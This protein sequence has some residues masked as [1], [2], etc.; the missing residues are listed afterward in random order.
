M[1]REQTN[2]SRR[3]RH[4]AEIRDFFGRIILLIQT[5]LSVIA[6]IFVWRANLLPAKFLI[7][8]LAVLAALVVGCYFLM[9]NGIHR[10]RFYIGGV[11]SVA[12]SVVLI[13]VIVVMSQMTGALRGIT[14]A[15]VETSTVCVYVLEEDSAQSITDVAG[16]PF[17]ILSSLD[18]ENTED[19]IEQIEEETAY[20]ISCAEYDDLGD[21]ADALLDGECRSI[22]LNEGFVGVL[23]DLEGYEEFDTQI[24]EIARYETEVIVEKEEEMT[25]E[26]VLDQGSFVLYISGIDTTGDVS[27]KGRSD[28]NILAVVNTDTRQILLVSTPRDYYVEL[29]ISNGVRDKLTHAGIYG[30]QVSMDTLEMLYDVDINY[31]FRLNFTGF[32]EV[33]DALGGIDV[34]SDYTFDG[35]SNTHFVKGMNHL[36]GAEA[37]A[38]ARERYSFSEGDRQRGKNQ[39]EVIRATLDAVMSPA[40]LRNFSGFMSSLEHS[41]DTDLPYDLLSELVKG[42]LQ[43]MS[44]W[45]IVSYS[46]NGSDSRSTT[47]SMNRS[48][49]VMIPDEETVEYGKELIRKVLA[50]EIVT[51]EE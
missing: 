13:I 7:L 3:E 8:V 21:L 40:I 1:N 47:Y 5:V 26:E 28:V 20:T 24:R 36:S 29:S 41:V 11:L 10:I 42:Q 16:D 17:G 19:A 51:V 25:V 2:L 46:V 27:S 30:V 31:Y 43:D 39:M 32:E 18:R 6:F 38:F 50:G 34:N 15:E 33:I 12:C 48:L 23:T 22:I 37:L 9:R 14:D 35:K 4:K 45:D 49:Y 44:S